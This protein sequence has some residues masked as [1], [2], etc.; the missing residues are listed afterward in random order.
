MKTDGFRVSLVDLGR[1][2]GFS[3]GNHGGFRS[4]WEMGDGTFGRW[5][6]ENQGTPGIKFSPDTSIDRG[7]FSQKNL[8]GIVGRDKPFPAGQSRPLHWSLNIK[9]ESNIPIKINCETS[10][11]GEQTKVMIKYNAFSLFKLENVHISIPIK[12]GEAPID[13]VTE[14]GRCWYDPGKTK[15]QS[16]VHWS[17][18]AIDD[19]N[20]N[21]SI[22][23]FVPG[24]L[25]VSKLF[26]ILVKFK[27]NDTYSNLKLTI[28][29]FKKQNAAP[30]FEHHKQLVAQK[31]EIEG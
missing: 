28:V 16:R 8:L 2:E 27:A 26:P 18:L 30:E 25:N 20:R 31:Y 12:S 29:P 9:D 23:F 15:E 7:I 3:G 6:I 14:V 11:V 19:S 5:E 21:G 24:A 4:V 10:A 22:K 17:I 13:K 1:I